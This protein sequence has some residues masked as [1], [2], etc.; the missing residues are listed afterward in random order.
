MSNARSA[1]SP[2]ARACSRTST[3][4][5]A[6]VRPTASGSA[7]TVRSTVRLRRGA[8]GRK[9]PSRTPRAPYIPLATAASH[10]DFRNGAP[11]YVPPAS[12]I[13]QRRAR[14]PGPELLLRG[15]GRRGRSGWRGGR[16]RRGRR[17]RSR[18]QLATLGR[19]AIPLVDLAGAGGVVADAVQLAAL[20]V[21]PL[22]DL[23]V[24]V[25]V[26]LHA[27]QLVVLEELPDVG[28]AV[29]VHVHLD[30]DLLAVDVVD[31]LLEA[32][33]EIHVELFQRG[34]AARVVVVVDAVDL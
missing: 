11:T 16:G 9:R 21:L 2:A 8:S 30:A 32:T 31:G 23:A 14:S 6:D 33:V 1:A 24:V 26:A 22:V 18:G 10:D 29:E 19:G 27:D 3:S 13:D 20:V 25:R 17:G 12:L 34:L 4:S 5:R 28:L 15:R 7:T